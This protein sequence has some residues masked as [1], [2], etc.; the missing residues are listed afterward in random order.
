MLSVLWVFSCSKKEILFICVCFCLNTCIMRVVLPVYEFGQ[1]SRLDLS[2]PISKLYYYVNILLSDVTVWS[3]EN[4]FFVGFSVNSTPKCAQFDIPT[5]CNVFIATSVMGLIFRK[6]NSFNKFNIKIW[7]K[8]CNIL[9]IQNKRRKISVF[10]QFHH[11][12]S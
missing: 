6:C 5:L 9:T 4:W 3:S 1:M 11:R 8:L 7:S 12:L 2:C 10:M